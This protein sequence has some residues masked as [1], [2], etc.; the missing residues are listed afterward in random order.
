MFPTITK[1]LIVDDM[2]TMRKL[3]RKTLNDHGYTQIVEADDGDHAWSELEKGLT[4]QQPIQLIISDWNMPRMSG[5]ELLR[6]MRMKEETRRI[7]LILLT[8]ET[9]KEQ[10]VEA[11]K[12]GVSAYI[13]KPFTPSIL[14]EKLGV[15]WSKISR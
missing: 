5:I 3:V 6:K 2:S 14:I 13:M 12:A 1:I 11:L 9:E 8:A 15:V 7:P 4:N 10:V